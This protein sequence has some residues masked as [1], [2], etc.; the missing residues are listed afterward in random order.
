MSGN[1]GLPIDAGAARGTHVPYVFIRFVFPTEVTP[2]LLIH[3]IFTV[4]SCFHTR[5]NNYIMQRENQKR[6]VA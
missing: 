3:N 6:L 2:R 5:N 4:G 1:N